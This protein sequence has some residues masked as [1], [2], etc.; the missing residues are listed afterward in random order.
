[1][2]LFLGPRCVAVSRNENC[3]ALLINDETV[4]GVWAA[5][6]RGGVFE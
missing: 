1:M 5:G 4:C 6:F 3:I 2:R